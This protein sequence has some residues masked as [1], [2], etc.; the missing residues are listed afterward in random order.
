MNL[1][2]NPTQPIPSLDE[3]ATRLIDPVEEG[4]P[5]I[6]PGFLPRKGQL[7]LVG[8]TNVGKSLIAL[9]VCSSLVT[10]NP[11]WNEF[12]PTLKAQ[13]ILYILGEHYNEV[14]QRLWQKTQLEM[15][16]QVF[17]L[18]PE[19]LGMERWLVTQGKP[20]LPAIARYRK[21]AE[22][23]DLIV[24]DPLSAFV[25]GLDAENDNVQMRLVLDLMSQISHSAGAASII[26]AH[27]G[28]PTM[29][30]KG[31]EHRRKSYATRGAS[32][33]EDA[34][35][36]IYYMNK[37]EDQQSS[38]D[39]TIYELFCRKYKGDA[40]ELIRLL[41]NPETLTHFAL[42][43]QP[44]SEVQKVA[45]RAKVER[46]QKYNPDINYRTAIRL[47]AAIDGLPEDTVARW[48]GV[49]SEAPIL[50]NVV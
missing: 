8:E 29:D 12:T 20:N 7:V 42:G 4:P 18:G 40:P 28:K 27:Q 39:G 1:V 45:Y 13:K 49:S 30:M 50:S 19:Q 16:D 21:W 11:L 10:G 14:I 24:W 26:L 43:K 48:L 25:S 47:V 32:G 9:E 36:N 6:L 34:A 35:T 37:A 2:Y 3:I 31:V 5:D 17:L 33:I 46:L 38:R 44:F 41:R 23:C 15:T 22:G